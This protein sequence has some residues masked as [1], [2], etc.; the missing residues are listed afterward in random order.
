MLLGHVVGE[1][2]D[3]LLAAPVVAAGRLHRE[4]DE[5]VQLARDGVLVVPDLV[6]GGVARAEAGA[7]GRRLDDGQIRGDGRRVRVEQDVRAVV[8]GRVGVVVGVVRRLDVRRDAVAGGDLGHGALDPLV[9][10]RG[11]DLGELGAVE[12]VRDELLRV[13]DALAADAAARLAVVDVERDG[14]ALHGEGDA[15]LLRREALLR[16]RLAEHGPHKDCRTRIQKRERFWNLSASESRETPC[17][18]WPS[19]TCCGRAAPRARRSLEGRRRSS[20]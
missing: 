3:E 15:V 7:E 16:R 8:H 5:D 11:R 19:R 14:V 13:G 2:A 1:P 18:T 9:A 20:S 4:R 6:V 12:R 10:R 17:W